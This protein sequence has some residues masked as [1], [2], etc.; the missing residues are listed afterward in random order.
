MWTSSEERA[1]VRPLGQLIL[2]LSFKDNMLEAGAAAADEK[3]TIQA[4]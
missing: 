3:D 1:A 2:I 4:T